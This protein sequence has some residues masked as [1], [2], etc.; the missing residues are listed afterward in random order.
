MAGPDRRATLSGALWSVAARV[1]PLASTVALSAVIARALGPAELGAQSFIAYVGSLVTGLVIMAATNCSVQVMAS[2]YGAGDAGRLA[3]LG[4]LSGRMHAI[5]GVVAGL[6]LGAIGAVRDHPLAWLLI[7]VVTFIDALGWSHGSRLIARHGWRA[8]SPLRLVS[9]VVASVLGVGAVLLGG[10]L[11]GVFGVQ[12][13]TAGWLALTLRR[14]D[15]RD[16]VPAAGPPAAL[17][18]APLA[19]MWGMFVL[20]AGLAEIVDRRVELLFL[21]AFSDERAVAAYAVAFSL[22]T[23]AM[24]GMLAFTT[25]AIPSIASAAATDAGRSLPAH[26][27]RAGRL[28]VLAGFLLSA[29]IAAVGPSAVLVFWGEGLREAATIT[30]AMAV[31]VLFVPLS[32][33][34]RAYWT[35][36]GN[37]TPVLLANG[38]G[39]AAD[40]GVAAALVPHVGVAGAVA[41]NI[42]AQVVLFVVIVLYTR[43]KRMAVGAAPAHLLRCAALALASGGAAWL[44]VRALAGFGAVAALFGGT[45]AFLAVLGVVGLLRGVVSEQDADWLA[46]ALPAV[47]RPALAAVG[48]LAWSRAARVPGDGPVGMT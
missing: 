35:G 39:G 11:A 15:R 31:S 46:G 7:G 36:V 18:L 47:A 30:P 48:G 13:L 19:R 25:A 37:L 38:L 44:A 17:T 32:M 45:A 42:A 23:V 41:A 4:R 8:V 20:S 16:G 3:A 10:G 22:T 6:G 12:V 40:V 2:A 29:G 34:L 28:A 21:D 5:G 9:Q 26:L 1:V 24:T 33:L 27:V 43:R 14:R